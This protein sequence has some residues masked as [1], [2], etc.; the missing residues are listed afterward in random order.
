[1]TPPPAARGTA[2]MGAPIP[3]PL[4]IEDIELDKPVSEMDEAEKKAA[5]DKV[6]AGLETRA[7]LGNKDV[8]ECVIESDTY[9]GVIKLKRPSCDEE[10]RIGIRT[11]QYLNGQVGVDVKTENM[12]IFFATFEIC[13]LWAETPEWFKPRQMPSSDYALLEF[14]YGGFAKWLGDFRSF[15]PR[16]RP[17][18]SEAPPV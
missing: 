9:N 12:A 18:D 11:A 6:L 3:A 16:E 15:V 17:G 4:P 14:V 10:R 1:M 8:F 7:A 5:R 13:V 2:R